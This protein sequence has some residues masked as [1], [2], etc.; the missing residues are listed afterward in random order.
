[1][2][3]GGEEKGC[4]WKEDIEDEEKGGGVMGEYELI[5]EESTGLVGALFFLWCL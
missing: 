4:I 5:V 2:K 1:M 3:R